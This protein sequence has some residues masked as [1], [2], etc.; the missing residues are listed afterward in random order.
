MAKNDQ[1]SN[2]GAENKA[3]SLSS[4]ISRGIQA[5]EFENLPETAQENT[6]H[7]S[8]HL[9]SFSFS[10]PTPTASTTFFTP[11][12]TA[13]PTTAVT[14]PTS[15]YEV[16][17]RASTPTSLLQNH[18]TTR[19]ADTRAKFLD[20]IRTRRDEGFGRDD[21]LLRADY[22]EERRAWE[23]EMRMREAEDAM[24]E[25]IEEDLDGN[26]AMSGVVSDT[27]HSIQEMAEMSPTEEKEIEA[28][29]ELWE[30]DVDGNG[31]G[32]SQEWDNVFMEVLSQEQQHQKP[33]T[34]GSLLAMNQEPDSISGGGV[35]APTDLD[36]DMS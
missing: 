21:K 15:R 8:E 32:D 11:S 30:G 18:A 28:L 33:Q 7:Q 9:K 3:F 24:G 5:E 16:R 13:G 12:T 22:L 6:A 20:R 2:Y 36:M 27:E 35:H 19:R 25:D 34:Q 23:R 29:L 10:S 17:S 14:A 31:D 1:S 26:M 4:P